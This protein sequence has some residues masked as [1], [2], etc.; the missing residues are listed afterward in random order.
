MW[1]VRGRGV[2]RILVGNLEGKTPLG[3]PR[4]KWE[5]NIIMDFSRSGIGRLRVRTG[6]GHL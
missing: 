4:R 5:D 2:C 6:G 3:R 1:H